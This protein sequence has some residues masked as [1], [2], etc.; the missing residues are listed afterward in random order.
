M[1]SSNNINA[2]QHQQLSHQYNILQQQQQPQHHQQQ[3]Q[4]HQQHYASRTSIGDEIKSNQNLQQHYQQQPSPHSKHQ[5]QY[6]KNSNQ[7]QQQQQQQSFQQ[8]QQIHSSNPSISKPIKE[9]K[10]FQRA[11][12]EP[13]SSPEHKSIPLESCTDSNENTANWSP[14]NNKVCYIFS[15]STLFRCRT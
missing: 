13:Q 7:H 11:F 1:N 4:Q 15:Y 2:A 8:H 14:S 10:S 9:T 5:Q 3:Q 12:D 6:Q